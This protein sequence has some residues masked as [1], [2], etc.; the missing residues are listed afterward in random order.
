MRYL[1]LD[2]ALAGADLV[3]TA[4]GGIDF[5]T[6]RGKI[7]TEVARRAKRAGLPTVALAGTV[8]K[9]AA[10]VYDHGI[11]AFF[12]VVDGPCSLEDAIARAPELVTAGAE[13]AMRLLLVGQG[14]HR[15]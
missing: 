13:N 9:D 1:D 11:D 14:P 4:E 2:G 5:Q 15:E 7:P 6:P 10:L 8:G 12:S 3:F